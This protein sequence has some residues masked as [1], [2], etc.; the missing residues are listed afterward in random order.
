MKA[1]F[2]GEYV[3]GFKGEKQEY[4]EKVIQFENNH[5]EEDTLETDARS[6]V[7]KR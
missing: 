2:K 1:K 5:L 7:K 3:E 4:S 6:D